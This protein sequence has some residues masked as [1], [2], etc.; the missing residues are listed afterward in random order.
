MAD[1]QRIFLTIGLTFIDPS[2][3]SMVLLDLYLNTFFFRG[4]ERW[5]GWYPR[6][7]IWIRLPHLRRRFPEWAELAMFMAV[8]H[9][10]WLGTYR[11]LSLLEAIL[12]TAWTV[13]VLLEYFIV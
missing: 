6:L 13:M 10:T 8:G 9:Y 7:D 11:G 12:E 2:L 3:V 4:R 5:H 1:L